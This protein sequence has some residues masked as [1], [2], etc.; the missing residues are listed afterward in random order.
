MTKCKSCP[1]DDSSCRGRTRREGTA[2]PLVRRDCPMAALRGRAAS[3]HN[4]GLQPLPATLEALLTHLGCQL[5]GG[6]WAR[7][8]GLRR[9]HLSSALSSLTE[10]LTASGSAE[11]ASKAPV[12][13]WHGPPQVTPVNVQVKGP[14]NTIARSSHTDRVHHSTESL[15]LLTQCNPQGSPDSTHH[16]VILIFQINSP[17]LT[18]EIKDI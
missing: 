9:A 10:G 14:V 4:S 5:Q 15:T 13:L 18:L 17:K 1:V 7:S 8:P 12:C 2:E 11:R 6:L 3:V 16:S